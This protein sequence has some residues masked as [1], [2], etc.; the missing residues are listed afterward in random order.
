MTALY[1]ATTH[2]RSADTRTPLPWT[3]LGRE[4]RC[5]ADDSKRVAPYIEG[6][7]HVACLLE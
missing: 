3:Q 4:L 7:V 6:A 5:C 2:R 1:R